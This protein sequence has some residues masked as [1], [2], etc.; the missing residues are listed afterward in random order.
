MISIYYENHEFTQHKAVKKPD[1]FLGIF[2]PNFTMLN[3][4]EIMSFYEKLDSVGSLSV[5]LKSTFMITLILFFV[6]NIAK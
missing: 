3:F 6:T 1:N 2:S 5:N 4:N